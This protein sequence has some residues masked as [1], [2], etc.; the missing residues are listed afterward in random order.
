MTTLHANRPWNSRPVILAAPADRRATFRSSTCN[1]LYIVRSLPSA[2]A[3]GDTPDFSAR[4]DELV[5][6]GRIAPRRAQHDRYAAAR[7]W[8]EADRLA[9]DNRPMEPVAWHAVGSLPQGLQLCDMR[10]IVRAFAE[11][12]L[13]DQGMIVDFGIHSRPESENVPAV[14][15]HV[16]MLITARCWDADRNPGKVMRGFMNSHA[17]RLKL[18]REW[19]QRTELQPAPGYELRPDCA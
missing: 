3:F 1:Y 9:M 15:P 12:L 14:L 11:D 16:H 2:D 4:R 5:A 17:T 10:E 19:Y 6:V 7:L 18:A 13:A 8:L